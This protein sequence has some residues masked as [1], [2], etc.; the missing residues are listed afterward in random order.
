MT[1]HAAG[2][3][4][5]ALA[6]SSAGSSAPAPGAPAGGDDFLAGASGT[7]TSRRASLRDLE[8]DARLIASGRARRLAR[9]AA[10]WPPRRSVLALAVERT[11][12]RGLLAPALAE[13]ARTRHTLETAVTPAGDRGKFENL[14]ALLAEH[15]VADR[16]WLLVLDDDVALPR[17]FLDRFLFL[18][19]SFELRL[20]QP[21]HRRRSH[22]AWE[23]TRRRRGSVVRET[24]FVEIGPVFALHRDTFSALLPFPPL[25]MG[26]GLDSH[27]AAVAREHGWRQG[28]VDALPVRHGLAEVGSGYSPAEAAAEARAFLAD[29]PYLPARETQRTLASHRD[30]RRPLG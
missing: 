7:V 11:D 26:W 5:A 21:A 28:V 4:R 30:W 9:D 17:G 22:A 12:R 15:P 10:A 8:L 13:L 29:R 24:R 25:R 19:E 23:I 18:A 27:W 2:R 1:A 20:A 3:V 14:D 6:R 16:D